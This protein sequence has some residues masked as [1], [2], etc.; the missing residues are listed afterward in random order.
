MGA[1]AA[2]RLD[3]L[4]VRADV[5][6]HA[7]HE[8]GA[9]AVLELEQLAEAL[10][11]LLLRELA[12]LEA[13]HALERAWILAEQAL[14]RVGIEPLVVAE[15]AE[16]VEDV[17]GEHAAEVHQQALHECAISR[18]FSASIGTPRS[19]RPRYSSSELP[20]WKRL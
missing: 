18:A 10:R 3:H 16:R 20:A 6:E 9:A 15:G 12:A 19:N 7:V 13:A 4:V 11:E 1:C 5:A 14:D 2:E 17:R 8:P